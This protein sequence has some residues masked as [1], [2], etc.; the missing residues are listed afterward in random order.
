MVAQ[1]KR[2]AGITPLQ[3]RTHYDTVHVP[4]LQSLFGVEFPLSHTRHYIAR[5]AIAAPRSGTN[6]N[7][8]YPAILY[9]E[10]FK[11]SDVEYDAIAILVFR[12]NEHFNRFKD[13]FFQEDIQQKIRDDEENF[14]DTQYKM[15]C[16][17]EEAVTTLGG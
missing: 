4:L 15:A 11:G 12:D 3:F 5:R 10:G 6:S 9:R 17:L 16:A 8:D 2:K 13:M 7:D 14:Q 1:I